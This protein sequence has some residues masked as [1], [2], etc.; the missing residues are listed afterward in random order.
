MVYVSGTPSVAHFLLTGTKMGVEGLAQWPVQ[1]TQLRGTPVWPQK[2]FTEI[3]SI[4]TPAEFAHMF[5]ALGEP[6]TG[7]IWPDAGLESATK[8]LN[9]GVAN[10]ITEFDIDPMQSTSSLSR[11]LRAVQRIN[12]PAFRSRTFSFPDVDYCFYVSDG[13]L[14]VTISDTDSSR[15]GSDEVAWLPA[16][17]HLDIRPVSSYFKVFVYAQPGGL[18]NLLYAVGKDKPHAGLHYMLPDSP[19]PLD[20]KNLSQYE[21]GFRFDLI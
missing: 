12:C 18:V 8:K 3:F 19:S 2:L 17:T 10:A 15:M 5:R 6:Y 1:N 16:G 4:I 13:N 21:S 7:L 11:S 9:S 14:E 20:R